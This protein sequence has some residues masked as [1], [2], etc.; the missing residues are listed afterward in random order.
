MLPPTAG[1]KEDKPLLILY[2]WVK[3]NFNVTRVGIWPELLSYK[4][5]ISEA[6]S[7][8]IRI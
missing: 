2:T 6:H 7:R 8:Q 3:G 4:N 1:A 5:Y